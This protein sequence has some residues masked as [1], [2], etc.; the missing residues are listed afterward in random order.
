MKTQLQHLHLDQTIPGQV[1]VWI[2]VAERSVNVL[3]EEVLAELVDVLNEMR[4]EEPPPTLIF[5]SAKRKGF[6]VGADL[7]R[8]LAMET[9]AEIQSFLL[10]GQAALENLEAYPGGTIALIQ[11]PCL[12]GGLEFAMAC[13]YRIASDAETTQLGMPEAKLG[14]MPGWGGTQ[15]LIEIIGY[16]HGLKMLLSGEP[17]NALQSLELQLVDKLFNDPS[18]EKD[19]SQFAEDV[20]RWKISKKQADRTDEETRKIVA[21]DFQDSKLS[22]PF[23]LSQ[24]A[25]FQ[26][27]TIGMDESRQDGFLAER[28]LF[29]PLLMPPAVRDGLQRFATRP[30]K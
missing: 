17:V 11:G 25:I 7:N 8:I 29:H 14:L 4:C 3:F 28:A 30:K 10:T 12:G 26:A 23:P 13:R 9:D 6:I 19:L 24:S 22:A 5:R 15:R 21:R 16:V 2:D 20:L 18:I 27:V 1:T